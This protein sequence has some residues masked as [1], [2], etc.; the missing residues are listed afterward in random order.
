ATFPVTK[1]G[2]NGSL[3]AL[4]VGVAVS[5]LT[6]FTAVAIVDRGLSPIGGI[7]TSIGMVRAHIGK[8]LLVWLIT[9]VTLIVGALLCVVGLLVFAPVALLFVVYAYRILS[10][11]SVAPTTI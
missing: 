6:L 7:K 3:V 11:G 10:G 4:V 9:Q 2:G 5:V 8:S 1:S